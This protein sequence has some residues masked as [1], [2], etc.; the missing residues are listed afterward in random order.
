MKDYYKINLGY[1]SVIWTSM[2]KEEDIKSKFSLKEV[3][4]PKQIHSNLLVLF[5]KDK[6]IECDGVL[7][8][9]K[10]VFLGVKTADCVPLILSHKEIIGA[11]H[12]GWRG[13]A[14]GI[15]ENLKI[16]LE[17]EGFSLKECS[18]FIGPSIGSCCYEVK[19]D[20]GNLFPDFFKDGK[21][22]LKGIILS[23][24][25]KNGVKVKNIKVEYAC[26]FC[27]KSLPSFRREKSKRRI[28]TGIYREK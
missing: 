11:L 1:S 22:D 5:E 14:G 4:F 2:L 20:V 12:C 23:F 9:E 16:F 17:K 13:L 27:N 18:F 19:E 7:T 21:V 10:N 15:L 26:T 6:N 8:R 3:Y 25:I 24:L 28:L